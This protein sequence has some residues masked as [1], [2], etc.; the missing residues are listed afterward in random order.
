M[1]LIIQIPCFNEEHTLPQTIADLP[2]SIEGISTIEVMVI[3][4]GSTDSTSEVARDLGVHHVLKNK[5]N[6]GLARS[7]QKGVNAC[8]DAGA[9]IIVNTDGDNQYAGSD[10]PKL[11]APILDGRADIVIGDRQTQ[12]IEHFSKE[13]KKL[14]RIGSWVVSK[15]AGV[16]I[17]DSVSG[18][19]AMSRLAAQQLNIVSSFSY[20]TEMAIQ[21]G[22]RKIAMVSVPIATNPKSRDSRLFKSLADFVGRTA[23]TMVR[24]FA[25]YH[26]LRVFLSLG[27]VLSALGLW[28]IIKFIWFYFSGDS[29]GHIQSL[30]IGSALL[31]M[32]FLAFM[33]GLLA[34]LIATNRHLLEM[35]LERLNQIQDDFKD[36]QP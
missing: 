30:V 9:D 4:D 32:G 36:K 12:V 33:I 20:T 23:T 14:Q 7:F 19:R 6:L 1:K 29:Q 24:T 15:L 17:P 22:R 13:K 35:T 21:A 31:T 28:P 25:M 34:D 2:K 16:E 5:H 10:I 18:F 3:D 27:L 11:T 8:L 26:P